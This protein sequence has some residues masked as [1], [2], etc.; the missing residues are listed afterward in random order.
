MA[1]EHCDCIMFRSSVSYSHKLTSLFN[2][3]RDCSVPIFLEHLVPLSYRSV[4]LNLTE[5]SIAYG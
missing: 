3:H 2:T 4:F 1:F 5:T